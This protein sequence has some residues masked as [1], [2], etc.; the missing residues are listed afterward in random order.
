MDLTAAIVPPL[1]A[2]DAS[3]GAIRS[4][5]TAKYDY[6]ARRREEERLGHKQRNESEVDGS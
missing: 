4:S 1:S 3:R 6:E 2:R 5:C